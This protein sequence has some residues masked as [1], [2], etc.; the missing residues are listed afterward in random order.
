[1]EY[2][3]IYTVNGGYWSVNPKNT[4]EGPGSIG[5]GSEFSIPR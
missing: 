4:P 1:M 5:D 2:I 3:Y